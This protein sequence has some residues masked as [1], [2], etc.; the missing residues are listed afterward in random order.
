RDSRRHSRRDARVS[1]SE[2]RAWSHDFIARLGRMLWLSLPHTQTKQN[3]RGF[4]NSSLTRRNF[5]RV[6]GGTAALAAVNPFALHAA[7]A[8]HKRPLKKAIMWG[9]V[10]IKGSV[11]ERCRILKEAGFEG[12]EPDSHMNQD[13]VMEAL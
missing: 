11:L 9:T 12:I 10:G 2:V 6:T 8:G 13:E 5:L 7:E 1:G 3:E 4:M